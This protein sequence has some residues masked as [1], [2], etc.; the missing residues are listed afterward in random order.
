MSGDGV[1]IPTSL[2]QMGNVAKSQAQSQNTT[3]PATSFS[4]QMGKQ[5]ELKVQRV[6]ETRESEETKV[7]REKEEMDKRKRRRLNRKRKTLK[8]NDFNSKSESEEDQDIEIE[9][10]GCLLDLRV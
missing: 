5:D 3:A 7:K 4:E 8:E 9:E 1:S 10:L 6:N 2:A